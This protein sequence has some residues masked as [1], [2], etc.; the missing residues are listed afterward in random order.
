[1]VPYQCVHSSLVCVVRFLNID[2]IHQMLKPNVL[3]C[4]LQDL[5]SIC[6]LGNASLYGTVWSS[7]KCASQEI[8]RPFRYDPFC[9]FL[10]HVL[11]EGETS[12]P[13]PLECTMYYG[14]VVSGRVGIKTTDGQMQKTSGAR[15]ND[16]KEEQEHHGCK[17]D[18]FRWKRTPF[19]LPSDFQKNFHLLKIKILF[20]GM[21]AFPFL[22]F[23]SSE[24][25]FLK[26]DAHYSCLFS[27]R[28]P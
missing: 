5:R 17:C 8:M 11:P 20:F 2:K 13:W 6:C 22:I 23:L 24:R 12:C 27:E 7:T 14:I 18:G 28:C 26:S 25:Q 4:L 21:L 19:V 15:K 10:L 16:A 3:C 1:M 9:S